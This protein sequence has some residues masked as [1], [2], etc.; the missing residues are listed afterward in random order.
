MCAAARTRQGIECLPETAAGLDKMG[1]TPT[2]DS[3]TGHRVKID[4]HMIVQECTFIF[5]DAKNTD[6]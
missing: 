4:Q 1:P 6:W 3:S 2:I 5:Y